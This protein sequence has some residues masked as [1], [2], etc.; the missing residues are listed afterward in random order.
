MDKAIS[1]D[2]IRA[3]N[4]GANFYTNI[5]VRVVTLDIYGRACSDIRF[6]AC[7]VVRE[8]DRL[9]RLG[10]SVGLVDCG[11]AWRLPAVAE[12]AA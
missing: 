12:V 11:P 4:H 6:L 2:T 8:F 7:D 3:I 10:Y 9:A 5:A 1:I